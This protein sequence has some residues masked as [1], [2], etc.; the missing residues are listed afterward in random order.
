MHNSSFKQ[1]VELFYTVLTWNLLPRTS[2]SM[3]E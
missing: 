2:F 3:Y 1:I